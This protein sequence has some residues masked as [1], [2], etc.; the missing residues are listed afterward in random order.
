ML[1]GM[2]D[3]LGSLDAG[4]YADMI[5]LDRNIFTIPMEEVKKAKVVTTIVNG[6]IV[7]K[8]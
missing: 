4:K 7:Y 2:E 3:K 5:V 1:H 6:K 8:A